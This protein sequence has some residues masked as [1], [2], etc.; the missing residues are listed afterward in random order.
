MSIINYFK[1]RT[2]TISLTADT[3]A[4]TNVIP[5]KNLYS[6]AIQPNF[7]IPVGITSLSVVF[8]I[9]TDKDLEVWADFDTQNLTESNNIL[10]TKVGSPFTG[11]RLA[12]TSNADGDVTIVTD[13]G[14][15]VG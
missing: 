13:I 8:Q 15:M 11:A 4:Y 14:K 5:L 10:Y 7:T 9:S 2:Q 3:E 12:I 1:E 6:F